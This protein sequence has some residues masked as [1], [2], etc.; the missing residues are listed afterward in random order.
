MLESCIRA[1]SLPPIES[2]IIFESENNL[3]YNSLVFG[4]LPSTNM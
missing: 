3:D 4:D 1:L 2:M